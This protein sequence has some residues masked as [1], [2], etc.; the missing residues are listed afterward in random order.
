MVTKLEPLG[1]QERLMDMHKLTTM[2]EENLKVYFKMA[3]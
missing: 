2:M 1:V 3:K